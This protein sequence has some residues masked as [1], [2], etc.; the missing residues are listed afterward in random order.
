MVKALIM[1]TSCTHK[2]YIKIVKSTHQNDMYPLYQLSSKG[3]T[4]QNECFLLIYEPKNLW[5]S[6]ISFS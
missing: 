1:H 6:N 5:F 4:Y 2:S 3:G